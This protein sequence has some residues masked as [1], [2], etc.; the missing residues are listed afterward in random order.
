MGLHEAYGPHGPHGMHEPM[1]TLMV[2]IKRFKCPQCS[3][4]S[5]SG[6][7]R[8][9]SSMSVFSALQLIGCVDHMVCSRPQRIA[10]VWCARALNTLP[11]CAYKHMLA[12]C[13][14]ST[15]YKD[16]HSQ[17]SPLAAV[18][19]PDTARNVQSLLL[20]PRPPVLHQFSSAYIFF[21]L[22]DAGAGRAGQA[23]QDGTAPPRAP[24]RPAAGL[25]PKAAAQQLPPGAS[26]FLAASR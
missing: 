8:P 9:K 18:V 7:V 5:V 24:S 14:T 6:I 19:L 3:R 4:V 13:C 1:Q 11:V 10:P 16:L 23:T 21:M 25:P 12:A 17:P 26:A 15:L 20:S 22:A 2:S